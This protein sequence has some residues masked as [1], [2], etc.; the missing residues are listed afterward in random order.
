MSSNSYIPKVTFAWSWSIIYLMQNHI[1]FASIFIYLFLYFIYF[2]IICTSIV[3]LE[4]K[5]PDQ[6]LYALQTEPARHPNF[7]I[8]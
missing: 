7:L 8:F 4:L 5:N 6:E 2:S 1:Q 3:G